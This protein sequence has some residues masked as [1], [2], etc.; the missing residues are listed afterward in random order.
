VTPSRSKGSETNVT[1]IRNGRHGTHR[2]IEL[3][4]G[5]SSGGVNP[6]TGLESAAKMHSCGDFDWC[7]PRDLL[8][9]QALGRTSLITSFFPT[10]RSAAL[11]RH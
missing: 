8:P 2:G 10:A 1:G 6:T 7:L 4:L 5:P 9:P 3:V 11:R